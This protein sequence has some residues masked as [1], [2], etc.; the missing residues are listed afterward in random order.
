MQYETIRKKG[1]Q[2]YGRDTYNL[3]H[4]PAPRGGCPET[5]GNLRQR[6]GLGNFSW[7]DCRWGKESPLL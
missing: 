2:L 6:M 7:G 4:L 1:I 5:E 3:D